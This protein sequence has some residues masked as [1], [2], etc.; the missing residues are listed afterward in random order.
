MAYVE[1]HAGAG[2]FRIAKQRIPQIP[3]DKVRISPDPLS[4]ELFDR[5]NARVRE[6][7]YLGSFAL[8]LHR[9][10]DWQHLDAQREVRGCLW[11]DHPTAVARIREFRFQLIPASIAC[12][13]PSGEPSTPDRIIES[14][15]E[16]SRQNFSVFWLCDPYFG[17]C[18]EEDKGWWRLLAEL[19][20]TYGMIFG[21]VG[22]NSKMRGSEKF[23]FQGVIGAP[24]RPWR[25]AEENTCAYGLFLT[26]A[27]KLLV[28]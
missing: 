22:G 28:S 23:D 6:G 24:V 21:Y 27:A 13:G 19:Q 18:K 20:D 16:F 17:K 10:A 1:S 12:E 8:V 2:Y 15:R 11:E 26:K 14:V 5:Y 25:Q 9:L 4:W 7:I 3:K